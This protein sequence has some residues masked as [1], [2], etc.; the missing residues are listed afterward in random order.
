MQNYTYVRNDILEVVEDSFNS[1]L[2]EGKDKRVFAHDV[3]YTYDDSKYIYLLLSPQERTVVYV[4]QT[5]NP[6]TRYSLREK[7]SVHKLDLFMLVVD[8]CHNSQTSLVGKIERSYIAF[9]KEFNFKN[10]LLPLLNCEGRFTSNYDSVYPVNVNVGHLIN[11]LYFSIKNR[12]EN[13][14]TID[15]LLERFY[16]ECENLINER[17][18]LFLETERKFKEFRDRKKKEEDKDLAMR[19][20]NFLNQGGCIEELLAIA[21]CG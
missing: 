15:A 2:S 21:V 13:G 17:K 6:Y 12:G 8:K 3:H 18:E 11:R 16:S 4:G 1:Y 10:R 20:R 14:Q 19:V 5:Y 9:F 7:S